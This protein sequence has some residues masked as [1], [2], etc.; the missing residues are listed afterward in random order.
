MTDLR[1][2]PGLMVPPMIYG[3]LMAEPVKQSYNVGA[4]KI[5]AADNQDSHVLTSPPVTDPASPLCLRTDSGMH[6][7]WS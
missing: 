6:Q 4:Y 1:R 7:W 2:K 3:D 5:G